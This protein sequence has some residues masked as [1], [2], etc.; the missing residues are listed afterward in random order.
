MTDSNSITDSLSRLP[1]DLFIQQITYLPFHQVTALCTSNTKL[2]NYCRNPDYSN[3]WKSLID[4]TFSMIYNYS[5]LLKEI[6]N[7]L[8]ASYNYLV[9]VGLIKKLDPLTQLMIY[10]RQKDMKSFNSERFTPEQRF[11]ALLLLNRSR[12]ELMKYLPESESEMERTDYLGYIDVMYTGQVSDEYLRKI[13]YMAT[14]QSRNIFTQQILNR[15]AISMAAEGNMKGLLLMKEKGA[16]IH[17]DFDFA[18][19]NAIIS[20]HLPVVKYLVEQG[21]RSHYNPKMLVEQF[22]AGKK[23]HEELIKYLESKFNFKA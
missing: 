10:Y 15:M 7:E 20:G 16:D 13:G 14:D 21:A 12:E 17:A 3:R 4:N 23:G 19:Q 6:Q 1:V 2:H 22:L 5:E 18:L 11:L 9:Y 8:K